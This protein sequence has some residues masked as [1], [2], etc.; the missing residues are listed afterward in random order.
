MT[1][2][3]VDCSSVPLYEGIVEQRE[4]K[5][6]IRIGDDRWV[7]DGE[8]MTIEGAN[9]GAVAHRFFNVAYEELRFDGAW[10]W[11]MGLM[12]GQEIIAIGAGFYEAKPANGQV[13]FEALACDKCPFI[14]SATFD[15]SSASIFDYEITLYYG[16][17]IVV[18]G[19]NAVIT[20][21][22]LSGTLVPSSHG[23]P[24]FCQFIPA[25]EGK[26]YVCL[27]R[28]LDITAPLDD[29]QQAL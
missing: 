12:K 15:F 27:G 24:N 2:T 19:S 26:L 13:M 20:F 18:T 4:G 28:A 25:Q 5:V 10:Y 11:E 7:R 8:T 14:S 1:P 23:G 3:K 6:G 29:D 21:E 16:Q 22:G 9:L 17:P